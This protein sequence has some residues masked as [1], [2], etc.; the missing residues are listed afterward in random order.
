MTVYFIVPEI[1]AAHFAEKVSL[2]MPMIGK[3]IKTLVFINHNSNIMICGQDIARLQCKV[4]K[5]S[6]Q[7][8]PIL[9]EGLYQD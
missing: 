7:K 8:R 5:I 4:S 1:N 3:I 9:K 2:Q 6:M